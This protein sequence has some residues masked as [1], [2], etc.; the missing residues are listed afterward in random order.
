[1]KTRIALLTGLL[2]LGVSH[3]AT[4]Y[5]DATGE[6]DPGLATGGGTLDIVGMEVSNT[7]TDI[8][9][10]LTVNG[11]IGTTDWGKFMIGI[12]N[13][14]VPG[15][16][17]GNGWGR[18]INMM[19]SGTSSNMTHWIGSWVD[20]GGG[21]Q[22]WSYDGAAWS[23]PAVPAEFS[24]TAG[25]TS[26]IQFT[27]SLNELGLAL[28]DTF[29]FDAYSSGGGGSDTAIDAL[30]NPNTSVSNWGES[31]LSSPTSE[32]GKGI[33]QYTLA[34][35]EPSAWFLMS[36]GAMAAIGLRRRR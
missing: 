28:G 12:A 25:A 18:P 14:N 3:A 24:F 8:N 33:N 1:M 27:V 22:V 6:I 21:A 23:G 26:D 29:W 5:S 13:G 32:G 20:A 11:N 17:V 15:A 36:A 16:A 35:P 34:V 19:A 10:K 7:A 2:S 30:A 31:Y 4:T 9:F